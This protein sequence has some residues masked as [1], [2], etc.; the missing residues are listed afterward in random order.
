MTYTFKLSRRLA[1]LPSSVMPI[2]LLVALLG[3][4]DDS[5][6]TGDS[7]GPT[8]DSAASSPVI[9]PQLA[10]AQT[11]QGVQFKVRS[12]SGGGSNSPTVQ[13]TASG[14]TITQT[15]MFT[16]SSPG[17][18]K[19]TAQS[20]QRQKSDSAIVT[21]VAA[22]T[23]LSAVVV[24]PD[25]VT[26]AIGASYTFTAEGRLGD[27]SVAVGVNWTATGGTIDAG[28]VYSA[29]SVA[30]TYHVVA[31]SVDGSL[32][33][34]SRVIIPAPAAAPPPPTSPPPAP[35]LIRLTLTPATVSLL[36]GAEQQFTASG[37]WSDSTTAPAKVVFSAAGGSVT[38]SGLYTAGSAPGSY[39]V[40]ARDSAGSLAD[41]STVTIA[42][43]GTT[44]V[45]TATSLCPGDDIAAKVAAAGA[46]TAFTLAPGLYRMQSVAPK[47]G[48]SF[49]GPRTAVLSG[50]ILVTGWTQTAGGWSAPVNYTPGPLSGTCASGTA[51]QNPNDLYRDDVL[52]RSGYTLTATTLTVTQDPTGHRLELAALPRAFTGGVSGVTLSG[53]TV[54]KY[55]APYNSGAINAASG[56]SWVIDGIEGR[57]NHGAAVFAGPN[58]K[59]TNGYFHHNGQYGLM[60][61]AAGMVIQGNEVAYNNT[62]GFSQSWA[63]GGAKFAFT[64]G[65]LVTGN[66]FHHNYGHAIWVDINNYQAVIERNRVED[67]YGR[68]VFYEISYDAVIRNNTFARNGFNAPVLLRG[69]CIGV[70]SSSNVEVYGN[71]CVGDKD[72]ITGVQD[73]RGSGPRG[74]YD[75]TNLNVHDNALSGIKAYTAGIVQ[76]VGDT[77]YYH[78]GNVFTGNTYS[79]LTSTTPYY[80]MNGARTPSQ[81]AGFGMQ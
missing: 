72:G 30:G 59:V 51:C 52:Q 42:S 66:F 13:W 49:T 62:A 28:G 80:W 24:T 3:C 36:P 69:G 27:S 2:A 39:R 68:G 10:V 76:T 63:A 58:G 17:K 71:T 7:S 53:F 26:V 78:R 23:G 33:D 9:T 40:I 12:R 1:T 67:N 15:G 57:W 56:P 4:N 34:T 43:T 11:N 31:T 32:A 61:N 65:L 54:E 14:G 45:S 81:W 48:D 29:D 18:Y 22:A 44:C 60:G 74:H 47:A 8:F 21:V 37:R 55:A 38:A 64:V 79:S 5:S 35:T 50:A 46:G 41:T 16:A 73:E 75:L 25:S 20:R 70:V 77:T 19:V 6:L